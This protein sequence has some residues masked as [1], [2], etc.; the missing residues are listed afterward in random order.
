MDRYRF[1]HTSPLLPVLNQVNAFH[2]P[3]SSFFEIHFICILLSTPRSS[4]WSFAFRFPTKYPWAF[5]FS[6]RHA[7]C[8]SALTFVGLFT[9]ITFGE[10]CNSRSSSSHYFSNLLLLCPPQFRTL[11]SAPCS[12]TSSGDVLLLKRGKKLKTRKF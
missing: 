1:R 7:T 4:R 6:S 10:R 12:Q 11:T 3:Q 2:A 5:V 9:L 8:L